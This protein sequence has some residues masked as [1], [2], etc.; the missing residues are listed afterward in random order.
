MVLSDAD[1]VIGTGVGNDQGVR[2]I[3]VTKAGDGWD[4]KQVWGTKGVRPYFNDAVA[5]GGHLYGF[6]D[7]R[8]CCVDLATGKQL[9][10][11]TS[12]GHG[13]VLGLPDQGLLVVQGAKGQVALVKADPGE[14]DE[15]AQFPALAG[16]TWNHPVVAH[17]RLYVRNGQEAACYRLP[18]R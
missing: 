9:W 15:L 7:D 5:V 11:E 2:R 17:G 3:R 13:Q 16:K 14:L 10:K 1:V 4:A 12:Y 8:F 6:D 18:T